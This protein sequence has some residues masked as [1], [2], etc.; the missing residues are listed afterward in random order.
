MDTEY[1]M[2]EC[3][4]MF[5]MRYCLKVPTGKSEWA[6]D[7]VTLNE[8]KEFSQAHLDEIITSHRVISGDEAAKIFK[9]DHDY[10]KHLKKEE[11]LNRFVHNITK[12]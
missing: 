10:L 11:I 9:E 7:T 1:V 3:V 2:V 6:L 8:A 5:R 12:D 4:S